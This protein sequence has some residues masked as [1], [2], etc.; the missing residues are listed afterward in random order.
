MIRNNDKRLLD[1]IVQKGKVFARMLPEQKIHLIECMKDLG[2]QVIMCGDGCNDCGA[3]KAAHA[4]ISLSMAEASVAAPFTSKNVH[5]ACVP[6]LIREGRAT[7]VSA[8]S[9]YKFGV[10]F[11]FTQLIAVLMVFYIGTEPSD[12]QYLVM[13]IGLAALPSVMIGNNG[14]HSTLIKQ[15]PTRHL[16]SFLP[17]FSVISFLL[18]QTLCYVGVWFYV[19]SQNWFEPYVFEAG[20]WPPNASYEQTNIFLLSCAAAVIGAIVFAKGAPYRTPI[21]KNGIMCAWTVAAVATTVFMCIYD[22]EDFRE[23]LNMKIAPTLEYKLVL[24]FIMVANFLFCYIWEV[25]FLDGILFAKILPWY[26]EHIRGPHLPFEHLEEE[27]KCKPGWPPIGNCK[28]NDTKIVMERDGKSSGNANVVDQQT[29][30]PGDGVSITFRSQL[31]NATR[32]IKNRWSSSG[33]DAATGIM[34][35]STEESQSLLSGAGD[36]LHETPT[37]LQ[38]QQPPKPL[39]RMNRN[40]H[41]QDSIPSIPPPPYPPAT[42][43]PALPPTSQLQRAINHTLRT[44]T[45]SNMLSTPDPLLSSVTDRTETIC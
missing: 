15:K 1:S 11:G 37:H 12:N 33:A 20:V 23:R 17:L 32:N 5:I 6:Y 25:F 13:D 36:L 45:E 22:T 14:P 24:V 42:S 19:Q 3:L 21:F 38:Q 30:T 4:G 43:S 40:I 8:F 16:L 18:F 35:G 39:D 29:Q 28:N 26:K 41:H 34:T 44:S 2:R 10:V 31:K 9:A 7:I 27:L